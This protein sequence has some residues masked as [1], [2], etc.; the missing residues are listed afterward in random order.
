MAKIVVDKSADK[1]S[2]KALGGL[3][4]AFTRSL[5]EGTVRTSHLRPAGQCEHQ[6]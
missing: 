1:T 2:G 4:G 5:L 6:A 3:K